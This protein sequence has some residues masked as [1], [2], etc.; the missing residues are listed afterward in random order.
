MVVGGYPSSKPRRASFSGLESFETYP[1][2]AVYA[3]AVP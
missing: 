3:L 1:P 2:S